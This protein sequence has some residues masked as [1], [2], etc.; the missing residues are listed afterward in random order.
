MIRPEHAAQAL[1]AP[2]GISVHEA[3]EGV[4]TGAPLPR[5]RLPRDPFAPPAESVLSSILN[6]KVGRNDPCTCGSGRKYKKCCGQ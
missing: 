6:R 2:I 5:E 1:G 3:V 4:L